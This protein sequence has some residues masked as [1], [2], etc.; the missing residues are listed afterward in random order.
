MPDASKA[1]CTYLARAVTPGT[2]VLPP[3]RAEQMYDIDV[4]GL[5]GAGGTLTVTGATADVASV[6]DTP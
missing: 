4:N 3:V 1:R 6:H 2:Y 5:S